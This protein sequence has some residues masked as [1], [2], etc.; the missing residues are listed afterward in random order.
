MNLYPSMHLIIINLHLGCLFWPKNFEL[1]S[2]I[3][4]TNMT[5]TSGLRS[6]ID[7]HLVLRDD[8]FITLAERGRGE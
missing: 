5:L 6:V 2:R 3:E 1:S 4:L 7:I 8:P